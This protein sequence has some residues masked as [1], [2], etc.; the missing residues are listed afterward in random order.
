MRL[1]AV[2][3]DLDP[4]RSA[5]IDQAIAELEGTVAEPRQLAQGIRP[6]R[7]DDG[8][9]PALEAVC[10]ATPIPVDLDVSPLSALDEVQTLS[11]Y[12]VV[13]EAVTNVLKHAHA[14]RVRVRID[15]AGGR[16]CVEV[17]DD[18]VGGVPVNGALTALRD[19]VE[20][21]GGTVTITSPAGTGTTITAV[22]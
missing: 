1:R 10:A 3:R 18:G 22:L 5:E 8:L 14:T 19:R 20:S 13:S 2:Q 7:L 15:E 4:A 17:S 16:L 21:V 9:G 11:A 6:G 12:L